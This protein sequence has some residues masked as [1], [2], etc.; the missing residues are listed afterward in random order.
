M[1]AKLIGEPFWRA[2]KER[3]VQK[4][5]EGDGPER[6]LVIPREVAPRQTKAHERAARA[7]AEEHLRARETA[8]A[9]PPAPV[10]AP[11]TLADLAPKVLV[12]WMAD[13]RLAPA[14]K[15]DRETDVRVWILPRFGATP[16]AEIDSSEVRAW[17]RELRRQRSAMRTRN[18]LS[19]FAT[20][21]A[22]LMAEKLMPRR[23]N[24][25]LDP[26]V[27]EEL[28]ALPKRRP[29]TI[30]TKA[31]E[32]LLADDGLL[33]VWRLRYAL[34]GLAGLEDGV[35][36][37]LQVGDI[38]R[39][40]RTLRIER[41]IAIR[42]PE[43]WASEKGPK[44]E[45]RCRTVPLHPALVALL[46]R[47]LAPSGGWE[48][49]TGCGRRAAANDLLLPSADGRPW[50][51]KSAKQVRRDLARVGIEAP[52]N[53]T[54]HRLRGCF[55]TWLAAQGVPLEV[56]RRLAG[57]A[58]ADVQA[59]HYLEQDALLD[60]DRAAIA[61]IPVTVPNPVPAVSR[62]A[63]E[64]SENSVETAEPPSRLE[65]ETYGLRNDRGGFGGSLAK[66]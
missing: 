11:L 39:A 7:W 36:A 66:S 12:L 60:A 27:R 33:D 37:G 41:A 58:G 2:T 55:L 10:V 43:G 19:T 52:D 30:M 4:Y 29:S 15:A 50:R 65:L 17:I 5:R 54:F 35:I 46:D 57:H 25:A 49:W 44:N 16:P 53:F 63:P 38:N 64:R 45:H 22:G 28:P 40:R 61:S 47:W 14:T 18:I 59:E 42:G 34:A 3:F 20:L 24:V 1:S 6:Q 62:A 51:P 13:E 32:T 9:E 23:D 31:F 48:A 21:L 56:R 8:S 26:A